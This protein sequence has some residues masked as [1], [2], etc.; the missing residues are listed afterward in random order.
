MTLPIL[1]QVAD[2]SAL[3]EL[4]IFSRAK[5]LGLKEFY[6]RREIMAIPVFSFLDERLEEFG[7]FIERPQLAH[8]R[9]AAWKAAHP[10][11]EEIRRSATLSSDE[12]KS[13]LA[14]I[15]LQMQ[16]EMET[17]YAQECQ[18]A[19]VAEVAALLGVAN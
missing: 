5:W 3:I 15:R 13:R 10:E 1:V 12:K 2:A 9:I 4:R 11:V 14:Q 17:W 19:L 18:S 6:N 8:Q 16:A 7:V